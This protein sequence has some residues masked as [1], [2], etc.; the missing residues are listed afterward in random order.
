MHAWDS[1]LTDVKFLGNAKKSSSFRIHPIA[2]LLV[3]VITCLV[4]YLLPMVALLPGVQVLQ[5]NEV[6]HVIRPEVNL[7]SFEAGARILSEYTS[8]IQRGFPWI[9]PFTNRGLGDPEILLKDDSA[10]RHCWKI[11][12]THSRFGVSLSYSGLIRTI[13][14]E[15]GKG[16]LEAPKNIRIWEIRRQRSEST[17]HSPLAKESPDSQPS[18]NMLILLASFVY[19]P[20]LTE[21]THNFTFNHIELP[22]KEI[23]VD[24]V[25][26]WGHSKFTCL[27]AFKIYGVQ[28]P[29]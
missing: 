28:F 19:D 10:H 20:T 29:R 9:G 13:V 7:A 27:S 23:I 26:N 8:P 22:V 16:I 12:N 17:S 21:S 24:I 2:L 14:V 6:T 4:I 5:P 25:D 11:R 15:H 1:A 3:S 18:P